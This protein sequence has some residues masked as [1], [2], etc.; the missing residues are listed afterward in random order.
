MADTKR[1]QIR[2]AGMDGWYRAVFETL[3]GHTFYK[4]VEL[5]PHDDFINLSSEEKE[6][7]LHT[8]HTTDGVDGEPGYPVARERFDLIE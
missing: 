4:S 3:S 1:I 5:M 7:L 6:K 8:L 2:F